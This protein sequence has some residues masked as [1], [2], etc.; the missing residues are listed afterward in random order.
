MR[1]NPFKTI[2]DNGDLKKVLVYGMSDILKPIYEP[3]NRWHKKDKPI[4]TKTGYEFWIYGVYDFNTETNQYNKWSGINF[5][6]TNYSCL[7]FALELLEI[8]GLTFN[9]TEDQNQC[10]N[11]IRRFLSELN[12][13]RIKFFADGPIK[14][15]FLDIHQ[16]NWESGNNHTKNLEQNWKK[17]WPEA[18]LFSNDSGEKGMV[19]DMLFGI[20]GV[21]KFE[22][23]I[24]ETVQSKGCIKIEKEEGKYKVHCVVD[25]SKYENIKYFAFFPSNENKAYI[26][27]NN[28]EMV[29]NTRENGE[30][31][32]VIDESL[33][34]FE[35]EK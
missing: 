7:N 4:I 6:N 15:R 9:F 21:V 20:D 31:I 3:L 11:E 22:N 5:F 1:K 28:K 29:N 14:Q 26:F 24:E 23:G 2:L 27:T 10:K 16:G 25:Y 17:Y 8:E 18:V 34:H 33:L 35:G 32:F 30:P 13:R 12:H 19:E